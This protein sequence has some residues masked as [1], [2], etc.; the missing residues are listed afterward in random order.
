[1]TK[2]EIKLKRDAFDQ[3]GLTVVVADSTV[4]YK[5]V[6]TQLSVDIRDK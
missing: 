3:R 5:D 4:S 2:V 1:M 6:C